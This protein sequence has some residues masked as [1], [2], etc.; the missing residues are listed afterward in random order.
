MGK[1]RHGEK[2]PVAGKDDQSVTR[3]MD[4]S[5]K[6]RERIREVM[7]GVDRTKQGPLNRI[8]DM[9]FI[10]ALAI[11]AAAR[12]VFDWVD[13][14]LSLEL[15]LLLLSVKIIWLIKV[16]NTY[17]HYIFMIMHRLD[18]HQNEMTDKLDR[19]E[20]ILAASSRE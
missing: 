16:Q 10:I 12:F 7:D 9:G 14:I 8:M 1:D 20:K 17:N 11:L 5:G 18:R 19:I 13:N 4:G 2:V 3:Q 6:E 15:G